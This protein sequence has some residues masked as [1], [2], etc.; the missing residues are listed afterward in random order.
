MTTTKWL[1]KPKVRE[2]YSAGCD[3]TIERMVH[4]GRLPPPEYPFGN[5]IPAWREDVLDA[6]DAKVIRG[7]LPATVRPLRPKAKAAAPKPDG[8][9]DGGTVAA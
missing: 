5:R 2:R 9:G 3:K 6:H 7:P 4:E 8:G 1:R